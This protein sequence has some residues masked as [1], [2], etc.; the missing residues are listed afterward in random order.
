MSS[1][2]MST[3]SPDSSESQKRKI[4][5]VA[6]ERYRLFTQSAPLSETD[7]LHDAFAARGFSLEVVDA[8]DP[9]VRWA[10]FAAVLPLGFWGYHRNAEAFLHWMEALTQ[11]GARLI[12]PPAVMRWNMEKTYLLELQRIGVEVAEL[13]HFP[14]GSKPDLR[15]ELAHKG[16]DRYVIK[17][18]ISAN[19]ENTRVAAGAPDAEV[20]ALAGTILHRC[21]LLVQPFFPEI[22]DDGECS[23]I[24][25]GNELI[26]AVMKRPKAG[27]FRSQPGYGATLQRTEPTAELAAQAIETVRLASSLVGP[28]SYAR[29]D[30]FVRNGRLHLMELEL[31]EPYLFMQG[32]DAQSAQRF[33]DALLRSL[34]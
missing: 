29:V 2:P 11:Q 14:A 24:V 19:A 5:F 18:T 6:S 4:A 17:P 32:G 16:W 3:S 12:N 27:D 13:L 15:A 23:L 30:G 31:I 33:V 34:A 21:G 9:A 25:A 26:H 10:D 8:H 7:L 28:L 22:T 1:S 20:L